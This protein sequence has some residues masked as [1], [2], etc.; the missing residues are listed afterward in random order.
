MVV[1]RRFNGRTGELLSGRR[2]TQ[3]ELAIIGTNH[4]VRD[5][6]VEPSA[7]PFDRLRANGV[8]SIP[9]SW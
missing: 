2:P 6:L 7:R 1:L 8:L 3:C 5:E 9:R 4:A